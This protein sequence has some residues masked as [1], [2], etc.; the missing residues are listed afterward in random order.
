MQSLLTS[1]TLVVT[2]KRSDKI[3]QELHFIKTC[4]MFK[5][6]EQKLLESLAVADDS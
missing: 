6:D 5:Y 2:F 3:Y 1:S 4:T